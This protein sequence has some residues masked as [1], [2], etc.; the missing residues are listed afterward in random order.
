V[1]RYTIVTDRNVTMEIFRD[2]EGLWFLASIS[3]PLSP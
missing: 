1:H 2:S 3:S